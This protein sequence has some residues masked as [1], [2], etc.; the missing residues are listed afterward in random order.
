MLNIY[1]TYPYLGSNDHEAPNPTKLS[2]INL[3]ISKGIYYYDKDS[4]SFKLNESWFSYFGYDRE[5]PNYLEKCPCGQSNL[6]YNHYFLNEE[7]GDITILGSS[8]AMKVLNVTTKRELK[9]KRHIETR[10]CKICGSEYRSINHHLCSSC[11]TT[12][13]S[14]G[15]CNICND[16]VFDSRSKKMCKLCDG[17]YEMKVHKCF[18]D[19]LTLYKLPCTHV[20]FK[21]DICKALYLRG[22]HNHHSYNVCKIC[23][24]RIDTKI[25]HYHV[26][27]KVFNKLICK[28]KGKGNCYKNGSKLFECAC[29]PTKCETCNRLK[30]GNCVF[31]KRLVEAKRFISR[32][33]MRG[34][35]YKGKT[36]LE[37]LQIDRPFYLW[38]VSKVDP[39]YNHLKD[40]YLLLAQYSHLLTN[41]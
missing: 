31:C 12:N 22:T 27:D 21:C 25:K 36:W 5:Y 30:F 15:H 17:G 13:I 16:L 10:N 8:C 24:E 3:S 35:K 32:E 19:T 34:S 11:S 7:T 18:K 2:D 4:R 9:D 38:L 40:H 39:K 20:M 14:V 41:T 26:D 29:L 1:K 28:G 37:I 23:N 33:V 6:K